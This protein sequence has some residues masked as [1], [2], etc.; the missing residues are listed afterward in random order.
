[1]DP[2]ENTSCPC[3]ALQVV[4]VDYLCP[5]CDSAGNANGVPH[6]WTCHVSFASEDIMHRHSD[7]DQG[8]VI[9]MM[10]GSHSRFERLAP[11]ES[12][13]RGVLPMH[14]IS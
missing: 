3:R 13:N 4:D 5:P 2:P 1:M 9:G 8:H 7:A 12:A 11:V 6:C 14:R 10:C